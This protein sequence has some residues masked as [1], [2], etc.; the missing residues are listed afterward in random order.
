MIASHSQPVTREGCMS[1]L[2][3]DPPGK[4]REFAEATR[5]LF[6]YLVATARRVLGDDDTCWDAVQEALVSLWRERQL[7]PNPRAWLVTAVVHRSLHLARCRARRKKHE[8]RA[9]FER[10]EDVNRDNPTREL[11]Y[12]ELRCAL[13]NALS[14]I[15]PE[16]RDVLVLS[17]FEDMEYEAIAARL[18]IPLGTVR[19][20]LNRSRKALR[21]ALIQVF[22]DQLQF[23]LQGRRGQ[24]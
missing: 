23:Q 13:D 6:G 18:D 1:Q 16:H 5:P 7:P 11:E 15:S 14:M 24:F 19:S 9:R 4:E 10:L 3:Q 12:E 17:V 21:E 2:V 8:I 20:R 22:P